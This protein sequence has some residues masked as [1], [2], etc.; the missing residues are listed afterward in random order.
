M[1]I[2]IFV[3]AALVVVWFLVSA[4]NRRAQESAVQVL[5]RTFAVPAGNTNAPISQEQAASTLNKLGISITVTRVDQQRQEIPKP[6]EIAPGIWR[7]NSDTAF[8]LTL[9]GLDG[10]TARSIHDIF[11]GLV[12][13]WD[14]R[15]KIVPLIAK[16]NI[17]CV[18]IDDYVRNYRSAYL[19]AVE[20]SKQQSPEWRSSGE[21][22]REDMLLEF[23]RTAV[24]SLPVVPQ[25]SRNYH[26]S[27]YDCA[28]ALFDEKPADITVDDDL[29]NRFGFDNIQFYL[30]VYDPTAACQPCHE[31]DLDHPERKQFENLVTAGLAVRG[32][33]IPP[34]SIV[35]GLRLKDMNELVSGLAPKPFGRKAKAAEFLLQLPDLKERIGKELPLRSF[36]CPLPLPAEFSRVELQKVADSIAYA[37]LISSLVVQ[38]FQAARQFKETVGSDSQFV[39]GWSV[40]ADQTACKTCRDAAAR[41]YARRNP[42]NLPIH[43]GC[44]CWLRTEY[45]DKGV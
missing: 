3:I 39:S 11:S 43:I 19:A 25:A 1:W 41:K 27:S 20:N 16:L 14:K 44:R 38:T 29:I 13:G 12:S 21:L 37:A 40:E 45:N 33:D 31:R 30:R 5:P 23:R 32:I 34:A 15:Q 8:P 2:V 42:P 26:E 22:D 17:E 24:S 36:F 4:R 9:R 7:F 18:E 10:T 28:V 6:E 35:A